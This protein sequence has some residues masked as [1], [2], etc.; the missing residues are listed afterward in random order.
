MSVVISPESVVLFIGDSITEWGRDYNDPASLG[1]GFVAK[2]AAGFAAANPAA[3]ATFV[4]RGIGGNRARDLRERWEIDALAL[5]PD[6]VTIMVGINDTWRRYDNGEVTSIASYINDLRTILSQL[7]DTTTAQVVLIEPF[8]CPI[9]PEQWA[10][11]SD[12][13]PRITAVRML[14]QEFGAS[15]VAA[16]ALFNQ[17]AI[18][19]GGDYARFAE[20]GVHL[21]DE[22]AAMLA[23]AWL[24]VVGF[25][26]E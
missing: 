2:A 13:D 16:D 4:N 22:G 3:H 24:S 6:V 23:A 7:R 18:N 21:S 9:S 17:A 11:R 26:D 1:H 5:N 12:L 15:L 25:E 19:A 8:L 14:A 20:D 10:W